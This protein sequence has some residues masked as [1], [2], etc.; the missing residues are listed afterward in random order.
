MEKNNTV[1]PQ[2]EKSYF[3]GGYWAYIGYSILVGFV[4]VITL[5]IALPWMLCLFQRWKAKHTVVCGKRM[6][7]DGT[8]LQLI[9]NYLL[10][11]FLSVITLGIYGL[12][13]S[14]NLQKWVTKHTHYEGETDNNSFFDGGVLGLIGTKLLC[15]LALLVPVVGLLPGPA[16]SSCGGRPVT[17]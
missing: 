2:E 16:L 17:L 11:C 6:Y 15:S 4:S 5:G 12:W 8:G 3:D 10:W 9:G 14:I 1:I 13:F 7:F